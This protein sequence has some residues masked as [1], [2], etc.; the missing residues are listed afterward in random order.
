[1]VYIICDVLQQ[2]VKCILNVRKLCV[3]NASAGHAHDDDDDDVDGDVC[4]LQWNIKFACYSFNSSSYK[5]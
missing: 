5:H 2:T 4:I 1:M 3:S